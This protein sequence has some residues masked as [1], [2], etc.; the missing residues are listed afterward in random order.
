[1]DGLP[2]LAMTISD[3]GSNGLTGAATANDP[4]VRFH[5][6]LTGRGEGILLR[7]KDEAG[8]LQVFRD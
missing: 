8:G 3:E 7:E 6:K 1:M 4:P 2:S 5:L